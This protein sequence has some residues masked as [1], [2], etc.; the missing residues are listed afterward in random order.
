[1]AAQIESYGLQPALRAEAQRNNVFAEVVFPLSP[2]TWILAIVG[3]KSFPSLKSFFSF[4]LY[5]NYNIDL[6]INQILDTTILS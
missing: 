6:D 5:Y 2:I 1:V 4:C 3:L